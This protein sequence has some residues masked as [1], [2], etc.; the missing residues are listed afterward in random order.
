MVRTIFVL[1]T[2]GLATFVI[3]SW[4]SS[5]PTDSKGEKRR[6]ATTDKPGPTRPAAAVTAENPVRKSGSRITQH[7]RA[8]A[9]QKV[10]RLDHPLTIRD[11]RVNI[12]SRQEVFSV[13]QGL[14]LFLGTEVDP[15]TLTKEEIKKLTLEEKLIVCRMPFLAIVASEEERTR[16]VAV[17]TIRG[18]KRVWRRF[19]EDDQAEPNKLRLVT[20][21][22]TFLRL[23]E[24]TRVKKDQLL[25]LVDPAI[26]RQETRIK[27]AKLDASE[28]ELRST[29]KTKEEAKNRY[30]A[31]ERA[32]FRTPGTVS[33]EEVRGHLLNYERYREE[34]NQK[35]ENVNVARQELGQANVTLK[36]YEIRASKA[37]V[38]TEI[39]KS[40]GEAVKEQD[41]IL[42][43]QN[44]DLL[45][46]KGLVDVQ[47]AKRLV[48]GMPVVVEPSQPEAP[49]GLLSGHR[50][51]VT[52]V[53]VS[54]G[55]RPVIVSGSED[56]TARVWNVV[57]EKDPRTGRPRW[58]GEA[59]YTLDHPAPVRS[60]ACTPL[61][62]PKNL[63]LTGTAD[64][65]GRLWELDNLD[66]NGQPLELAESHG[67]PINV[68]AFNRDGTVCATGSEDRSV[69]LWYTA[70][71]KLK[72][73]IGEAHKGAVT[74]LAFTPKNQLVSV[75][76]DRQIIVWSLAGETPSHESEIPN[77]G[78]N[79]DHL[80]VS[81]DGT[82]VLFDQ[83]R[84]LRVMSLTDGTTRG[85]ITNT[86][87]T[88]NFTGFAQFAPDG[89]SVLTTCLSENRLQLWR[90]PVSNPRGRATEMRQYIWAD[91]PTTCAAF[92]PKDPFVV[93][94]TQ[95]HQVV[96]WALPTAEEFQEARPNAVLTHIGQFLDSSS[97]QVGITAE[98][99]TRTIGLIPGST[100][101]MVVYPK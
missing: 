46:A 100:A 8:I 40:S 66:K 48:E 37:G 24:G 69:C 101:T 91:A 44:P 90:N 18:D 43:L 15:K 11:T 94:G 10:T 58:V 87:G 59:I 61:G 85:I 78:G 64:G 60:V 96:I 70:T 50:E 76:R 55:P 71:G 88:A 84:Q 30:D 49:A 42:Q 75:G 5:G 73:R 12:I 38:I 80:G 53:A 4:A 1:G 62:A 68:V 65:V 36:L 57:Q 19:V 95:N 17:F 89:Q 98:I 9:V 13:R 63:C 99:H 56:H 25:G 27:I 3:V 7:A 83:G 32:N 72:A 51:K 23:H 16:G 14:I 21:E 93:T 97:R 45:Q 81:A 20:E 39:Y 52:S 28:A 54:N 6:E 2:L 41:P 33:A 29:I 74:A 35:R 92:S 86:T 47:D 77:L 31:A 67:G 26:A 79:V 22:K 34:E 82:Q